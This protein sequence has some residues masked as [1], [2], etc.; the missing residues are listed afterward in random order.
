[1]M[2]EIDVVSCAGRHFDRDMTVFARGIVVVGKT[3]RAH[4]RLR[5]LS[6]DLSDLM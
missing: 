5:C 4:V 2:S 3:I 6:E 1:M